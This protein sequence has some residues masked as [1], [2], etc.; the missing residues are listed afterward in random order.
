MVA[1]QGRLVLIVGPSGVG[2]DTLIAYSRS[3][4]A[5]IGD[6]VFPRRTITRP[7]DDTEDHDQVSDDEF[8]R[9]AAAGAFALH[10]EAHGLYYGV[11]ASIDDD[12]AAGRT[13]VV[14]VSRSVVDAARELDCR[15]MVVLVTARREAVVERL[16][17]RGRETSDEIERRV[18]RGDA[19]VVCGSDVVQIDNSDA[20]SI[21]GEALLSLLTARAE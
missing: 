12:L 18:A 5:G 11:P 3:R 13:V 6:V 15:V 17:R 21:A 16:N 19:I 14:N 1:R 20:V 4:L 2:K 8:R 7:V 10:W 9:Q